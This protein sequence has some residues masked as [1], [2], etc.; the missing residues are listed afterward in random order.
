MSGEQTRPA[1]DG[2]TCATAD[3]PQRTSAACT[4]S[5]SAFEIP[6]IRSSSHSTVSLPGALATLASR[7]PA[8]PPPREASVRF[9]RQILNEK[10]RHKVR[11]WNVQS[12]SNGTSEALLW[13][14]REHAHKCHQRSH[15][16]HQMP[17]LLRPV[18]SNGWSQSGQ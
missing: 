17:S 3:P 16:V 5:S 1:S 8:L 10:A 14:S 4:A 7:L 6:F 12:E 9:S 15:C 11:A 2:A 13:R 18:A